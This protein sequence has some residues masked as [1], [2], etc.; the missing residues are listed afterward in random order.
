M[1]PTNPGSLVLWVGP[2]SEKTESQALQAMKYI[3]EDPSGFKKFIRKVAKLEENLT[4][5]RKSIKL[6]VRKA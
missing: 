2:G 4:R 6:R 5:K 3:E 1:R